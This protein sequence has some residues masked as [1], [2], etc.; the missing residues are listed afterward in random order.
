MGMERE[1]P[2][3]ERIIGAESVEREREQ[4]IRTVEF[5]L[6]PR[7]SG[8]QPEAWPGSGSSGGTQHRVRT[9][10]QP[11]TARPILIRCYPQ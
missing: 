11:A 2:P 8:P 7:Q 4:L 1:G 3:E 10:A 9:F 6:G 5:A